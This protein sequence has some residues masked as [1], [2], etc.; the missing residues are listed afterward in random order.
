MRGKGP[1]EAWE[2]SLERRLRKPKAGCARK[3]AG[4]M[5][6]LRKDWCAWRGGRGACGADAFWCGSQCADSALLRTNLL[7]HAC[8]GERS[9][10]T[11]C[12]GEVKID[13]LR[14]QK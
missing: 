6:A 5:P 11:Q 3:G 2:S 8:K 12:M 13:N 7:S 10:T 9:Q 4:K 1:S 14:F